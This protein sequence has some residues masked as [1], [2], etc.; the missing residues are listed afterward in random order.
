MQG[1][2]SH[3]GHSNRFLPV[4]LRGPGSAA[5]PTAL[6]PRRECAAPVS[7]LAQALAVVTWLAHAVFHLN[8]TLFTAPGIGQRPPWLNATVNRF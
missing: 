7:E 6:L 1:S 4:V 5:L 3:R 2:V 8:Q